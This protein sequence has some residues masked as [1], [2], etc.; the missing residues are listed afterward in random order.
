MDTSRQRYEMEATGWQRG[1]YDDVRA[2]FRA[3]IVNWIWRTTMANYPDFCRYLWSQVKPLFETKAFARFSVRYRETVLS[4]IESEVEIPTYRRSELGV[5]P[6]EYTELRGQLATFDVVAPRLAVLFR[7]T[8]RALHGESVGAS[9]GTDRAATAPFPDWLDAGRGREPSMVPVDEFDEDITETA[10]QF[11]RF[12]G[13]DDGLPS[14]YRCLAQWPTLFDALWADLGPVLESETFTAACD[15]ADECTDAFVD[16]VPYSPR[17]AP[18]ALATQGFDE[19]LVAD[20]QQLFREFDEG[21]LD[22]VIPGLHLWAATVDA[23]GE[24]DW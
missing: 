21:A 23:V 4:A 12:H 8:N 18:D 7:V 19:A 16:S 5:R 10:A 22:D 3:P 1:V 15:R 2:T 17:L 24:R 11:Q 13:F 9:R 14:I 6:A 20:V